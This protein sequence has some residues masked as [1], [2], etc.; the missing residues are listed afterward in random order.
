[1]ILQDDMPYDPLK[2]RPLP[3]ISPLEMGDW[4][5]RDSAFDPQTKLRAQL[6]DESRDAVLALD[7]S[8]REA[9]QELLDL[10]I[11][12][13]G[14]QVTGAQVTRSDGQVFG[15]DRGD[16]L[17][18]LAH[19]IQEDICILQK[20]GDEHVLTG[21]LLCFPASWTLAEKFMR[22][23]V[24]IHGPVDSYDDNIARRVQRLF[25][26]V[27]VGRPLWRFNAMYY[28]DPALFQP[29]LETAPRDDSDPEQ[30]GFL[31]S[32]RQCLVRL[33][34]SDAVV[35]SIHTYVLTRAHVAQLFGQSDKV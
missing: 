24:A 20:R 6:V 11:A 19:L 4:L 31:R 7:P 27:R 15:L 32:E 2:S 28:K 34:K 12:Q 13:S 10:V 21:A 8:A 14:A 22:P 33:P 25:D 17:A 26:G 23:M 5:L 30:A 3:G 16:P 1:M 29:R 35:F 9:G 18:V